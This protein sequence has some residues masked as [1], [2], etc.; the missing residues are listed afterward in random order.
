MTCVDGRGSSLIP[1]IYAWT[2]EFM[3]ARKGETYPRHGAG[4]HPA[5]GTGTQAGE[6]ELKQLVADLS[7]EGYRLKKT[8]IPILHAAAGI[9][10]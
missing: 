6:L 5:G 9:N 1:T 2:N 7:L 8:A 4:R 10:G 3:E